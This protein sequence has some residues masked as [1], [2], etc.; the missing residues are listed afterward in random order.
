KG[1]QSLSST[2]HTVKNF[3]LL[4]HSAN[5]NEKI[6]LDSSGRL[7]VPGNDFTDSEKIK[8]AYN[9]TY[10]KENENLNYT[11]N[12]PISKINKSI[13]LGLS[14]VFINQSGE[15]T[16]EYLVNMEEDNPNTWI[17]IEL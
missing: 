3:K 6:V 10:S 9:Y 16:E 8:N 2:D 5:G 1:K 11:F 14:T 7:E 15:I 13:H 17:Q 12:I 4:L